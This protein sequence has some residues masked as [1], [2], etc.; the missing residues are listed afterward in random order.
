MPAR[1]TPRSQERIDLPSSGITRGW[2]NKR[3]GA[4]E[5]MHDGGRLLR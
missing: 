2:Y 3:R 5:L 1:K 4:K